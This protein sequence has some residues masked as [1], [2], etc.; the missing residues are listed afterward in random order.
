[1]NKVTGVVALSLG[2]LVSL[3]ALKAQEITVTQYKYVVTRLETKHGQK[4]QDTFTKITYV[5][6]D[7]RTLDKYHD[8]DGL[9][10]ESIYDPQAKVAIRLDITHKTAIRMTGMGEEYANSGVQGTYL[11]TKTIQGQVCKGY[12][13]EMNGVTVETWPFDDPTSGAG[14][15]ARFVTWLPN[16]NQ[17]SENLEEVT[18]NVSISEGSFEI[19]AG[20]TT[21]EKPKP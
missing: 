1:M 3:P 21:T 15:N 12:K 8:P 20:F 13:S 6:P 19:P 4:T 7:G 14:L 11:G 5:A 2:L 16:G 9:D 18:K 17:W 10:M